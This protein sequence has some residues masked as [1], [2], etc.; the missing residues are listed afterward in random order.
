MRRPSLLPACS[1][2]SC[3]WCSRR[4]APPLRLRRAAASALSEPPRPRRGE[5]WPHGQQPSPAQH[6]QQDHHRPR[7][8]GPARRHRALR[9]VLRR[10][11]GVTIGAGLAGSWRHPACAA[12]AVASCRSWWTAN[13]PPPALR[14]RTRRLTRWSAS[15]STAPPTAETG[16]RAVGGTINIILREA[17]GSPTTGCASAPAWSAASRRPTS[18]GRATSSSAT[19]PSAPCR[20]T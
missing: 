7:G 11:P 5:W 8:A 18:A 15:R 9:D 14:W 10:P 12:W 2:R 4:P 16:A 13:A 1:R 17:A 6:G 3:G 20:S 19:S